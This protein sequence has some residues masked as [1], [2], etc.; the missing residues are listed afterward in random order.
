ML[1]GNF[2]FI[3]KRI[4]SPGSP[5]IVEKIK[6]SPHPKDLTI[7]PDG[8]DKKVL[9]KPITDDSKAYCV[10]EN[11]FLHNIDKYATNAAEP[12]P[13][14]KF[15]PDIAINRKLNSGPTLFNIT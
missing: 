8:A 5:I 11:S 12:R 3:Q 1:I 9:A 2:L 7:N 14:E 4:K 10:P 15:S 13:P 6:K